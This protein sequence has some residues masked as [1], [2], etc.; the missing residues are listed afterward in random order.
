M[1][2]RKLTK[3]EKR[4]NRDR[5]RERFHLERRKNL[6]AEPGQSPLV[7]VLDHLKPDFNVGKIFRT[8]D[9]F[10]VRE[11]HMVGMEY[12]DPSPAMGSFR[13]VPAHFHDDFAAC[14]DALVARDYALF[15]LDVA[16]PERLDTVRF[17]ERSAF[18]MGHEQLG[19]SF[20][21]S[22]YPRV[23]GLVIPQFGK[24]QSLNVSIA[25]A[26]VMYEYL[27]QWPPGAGVSVGEPR[28]T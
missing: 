16:G 21:L 19:L 9:A 17:P 8:A 23:R 28:E 18:I 13:W 22:D 20:K 7:M 12:F 5:A 3:K 15:A 11:V 6:L 10:A 2:D 24:V 27:R 25:A 4:D 26:V 1:T 14:H